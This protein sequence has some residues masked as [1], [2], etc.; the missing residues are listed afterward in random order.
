M[1][2][3]WK[4]NKT[5]TCREIYTVDRFTRER[6]LAVGV[7]VFQQTYWQFHFCDQMFL[8]QIL[9]VYGTP[10]TF[11][12]FLSNTAALGWGKVVSW[13]IPLVPHP[14]KMYSLAAKSEIHGIM[15]YAISSCSE[16]PAS[17][18]ITPPHLAAWRTRN[19][20][21]NGVLFRKWQLFWEKANTVKTS[22][23]RIFSLPR[24]EQ[25]LA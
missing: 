9:G 14:D 2:P 23:T 21:G 6:L 17:P 8:Y 16:R 5:G 22:I 4:T 1:A 19:Y 12:S 11:I 18:P 20:L 3:Q 7:F 10:L 24:K 25:A 13:Q 15:R